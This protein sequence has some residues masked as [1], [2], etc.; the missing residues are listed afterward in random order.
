MRKIV[1]SLP[2]LLLLTCTTHLLGQLG[3]L[4]DAFEVSIDPSG[5]DKALPTS[6]TFDYEY[7]LENIYKGK[8]DTIVIHMNK[9]A[10]IV[11]VVEDGKDETDIILTDHSLKKSLLYKIGK[12]N[13]NKGMMK[14]PYMDLRKIAKKMADRNSTNSTIVPTG[15]TK[16]IEGY[17]CEEYK[18]SDSKNTGYIYVSNDT[19]I[20]GFNIAGISNVDLPNSTSSLPGFQDALLM[21]MTSHNKKNPKKNA[22]GFRCVK[23]NKSKLELNNSEFHRTN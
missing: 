13:G 3:D 6:Y 23:L 11:A 12:R 2:F 15:K 14:L 16:I 20:A 22:Y 1:F 8:K 19:E 9:S 10:S 4:L 21:E 17:V 7:Q 5:K 18:T